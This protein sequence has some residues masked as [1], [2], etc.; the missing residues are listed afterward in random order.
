MPPLSADRVGTW[1]D[2]CERS[3]QLLAMLDGRMNEVQAAHG[4]Q[5]IDL[6]AYMLRDVAALLLLRMDGASGT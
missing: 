2:D 4:E 5:Q 6:L 1:L 3:I